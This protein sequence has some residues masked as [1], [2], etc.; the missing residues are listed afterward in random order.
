MK[1]L[2]N[3]IPALIFASAAHAQSFELR[4]PPEPLSAAPQIAN[5][6]KAVV[7]D[8]PATFIFD[9]STGETCTATAV[10]PH[11]GRPK[12]A[13]VLLTQV[14]PELT[15]WAQFFAAGA[16]KR[17]AAEAGLAGV[18]TP[19]EADDLLRDAQSFLSVVETTL[20]AQLAG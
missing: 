9:A 10:G 5:G 12:S 2:K 19:R 6:H 3:I 13:W 7:A 15:E 4:R 1:I 16:Q 11:R 17:A 18:V 14:A 8:W 20:L